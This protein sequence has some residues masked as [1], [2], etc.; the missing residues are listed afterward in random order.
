MAALK[1]SIALCTYNGE[2]FLCEQLDS[3]ARQTRLP[4]ELVICDDDSRDGTLDIIHTF[5]AS[6]PFSV[7]LSKNSGN[8]GS[9][10][11]FQHAIALCEGDAIALADQ[12]DVWHPDKLK[13][14]EEF[15][16][17]SPKIDAVF[18][19]A[20]VVDE[21]LSPLG[22]TLWDTFRFKKREKNKFSRGKAFDVLLNHNVVTGATMAFRSRLRG[23]LFPIPPLW[24]HDKWIAMIVSIVG[25]VGF[26]DQCL[27]HYRQH[28]R[29]QIGGSNH[30]NYQKAKL[31]K[32]VTDY[33]K[34][35]QEYK[36]L[37][38]YLQKQ[39]SIKRSY[40][41]ERI[42]GKI[43]HLEMRGT[44]YRSNLPDKIVRA[45][46]ELLRGHYHAYSSGFNSLC[47][48]LILI[49]ALKQKE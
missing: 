5:A 1:I 25:E 41:M 2:G 11:N 45:F 34:Q 46:T 36:Y 29:Q 28:G 23:S 8:I 9:S 7:R 4:D 15:F 31:S 19:N 12:D 10:M 16:R 3:I 26:I 44:I 27:L 38:D 30:S 49:G 14:V 48:D 39:E 32:N 20:N 33:D 40:C 24:I 18:S 13:L 37:V 42:L 47:K 17:T 21:G 43:S 35:I 6:A 22:Y